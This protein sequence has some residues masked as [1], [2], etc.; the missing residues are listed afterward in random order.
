MRGV[1]RGRPPCATSR[2]TRAPAA[3]ATWPPRGTLPCMAALAETAL[4]TLR[5]DATDPRERGR[6][7]RGGAGR[8]RGALPRRLP[9]ALRRAGQPRTTC[10][11]SARAC[12]SAPRRWHPPLADGAG[13]VR[14]RAPRLEPELVAALN[15]RTE[16][17]CARGVHDRRAPREPGG[18]VAGAE[19][20]LVR[21]RSR[22][23]RRLVGRGRGRALRDDDRGRDPGQGRR[24]DARDRRRAQHPLPRERRPR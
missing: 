16:L 22:A 21:R 23:L 7:R 1:S 18:P 20:G 19:L 4:A 14:A 24:L 6:A 2:V 11:G 5:T 17:L 15:G 9:A 13:G 10:G 12:S 3:S 8:P